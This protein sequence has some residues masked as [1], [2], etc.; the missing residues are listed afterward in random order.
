MQ[1]GFN[2][3]GNKLHTVVTGIVSGLSSFFPINKG[4]DIFYT[5]ANGN[6]G[7]VNTWATVSGKSGKLPTSSDDVYIKHICYTNLNTA[8]VNNMYVSAEAVLKYDNVGS[9]SRVVNVLGKLDCQGTID[10]TS[11]TGF[12]LMVRLHGTYN[13]IANYVKNEVPTTGGIE[14]AGNVEQYIIPLNYRRLMLS[15]TGTKFLSG[16]IKVDYS[17]NINS[18]TA[19]EL[20]GYDLITASTLMNGSITRRY[21][22]GKTIF[23]GGLT[24]GNG[25]SNVFDFSAGNADVEFQN[26]GI[27]HNNSFNGAS[28]FR[29]GTGTW[30]FTTNNQSINDSNANGI[31]PFRGD[32]FVDNNITLTIGQG[33]GTRITVQ[34]YG[35]TIAGNASSNVIVKDRLYFMTQTAADNFMLGGLFDFHTFS[36]SEHRIGY[37]FNGNYTI[38]AYSSFG[39]LYVTGTGTKTLSINTT[40]AGVLDMNTQGVNGNPTILELST[41]NLTVSSFTYFTGNNTLSKTGSGS[42][43]FIGN[44]SSQNQNNITVSFTGNPSVEVRNGFNFGNN[45]GTFVSGNGTWTFS[46]NNQLFGTSNTDC[47][48]TGPVI[49][50]NIEL[51]FGNFT[52]GTSNENALVTISNYI[53]G[54]TGGSKLINRLRLRVN[55]TTPLMTTG[56][57]DFTTYVNVLGFVMNSAFSIPY[58]SLSGLEIRGTGDKT[59]SGNTTLTGNLFIANSGILEC[60][61]YNLTVGGQTTISSSIAA[62]GTFRK[63]GAGNLSFTGLIFFDNFGSNEFNVS[64]ATQV[65]LKGGINFGNNII[66]FNTGVG[67][68]LI[69]TNNQTFQGIGVQVL[70]FTASLTIQ[71]AITLTCNHVNSGLIFTSSV[72]GNNVNSILNNTAIIKYRNATAPM[73]TGKLYTNQNTTNTFHYDA[74][75]NQDIKTPDDPTDPGYRN[76]T[77][78]GS[79]AKRLLGNVS[80]KGTY[81][82]TAPATLDSNGFS[83]TNP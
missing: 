73:V 3:L 75:F 2:F 56:L 48:F 4:T 68:W 18:G 67:S 34:V 60:S 57:V 72:N 12:N 39:G 64:G 20:L 54:T 25:G 10:S 55:T 47:N 6:W 26:G 40:L 49:I 32:I 42:V 9:F 70:D 7:D 33:V 38:P 44:V 30:R 62:N 79:G 29:S 61:T 16:N 14:Y 74:A 24:L 71:G 69:N 27:V 17:L 35:N 53:D 65:E 59:L 50:N 77:L 13:T 80:V 22:T 51:T 82:L 23:T 43:L 8:T 81:T 66:V 5:V 15:G 31:L 78:A 36:W 1:S 83:L 41:Y 76:L 46:T 58:T 37:V 63:S 19:I 45:F 28:R 21:S 11:A 52:T